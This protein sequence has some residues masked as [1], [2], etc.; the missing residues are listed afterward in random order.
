MEQQKPKSRRGFASMDRAKMLEICSKGGKASH[1]KG[2]GH[3]WTKEEAI[4][5][6][7]KGGLVSRGGR[8]KLILPQQEQTNPDL[9]SK[10]N[11]T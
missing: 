7:R 1:A 3:E 2:T 11:N 8:G 4:E 5:A 6:G 10:Q 9:N